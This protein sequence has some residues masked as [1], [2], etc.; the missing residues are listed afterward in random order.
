MATK[1]DVV[2]IGGGH[3]GLVTAFYLARA[4]RKPLVLER[5][6]AVGGAAITDE[7]HAGFKVPTLAHTLGP[8]R[9][10]VARDMALERHGLQVIRPEVRVFAPHPDGRALFLYDDAERSGK[11]IAAFSAKDATKYA[12][13]QG[14]LGRI[15][16][17][18][19]QVL[20]MPPPSLDHP[21]SGDLW[22]LL[23]IGRGLRGLGKKEMYHVLRW[24]PMAVADLVA[25]FFETEL[26]RAVIA[27]RGVFGASLGP[28]SAGTS[29]MLLMR[30]AGDGNPAGPTLFPKGGMGA[31]TQAMAAAATQA[32]AEIRTG[33]DVR[34]IQIKDGRAT[35][36][37]LASGETIEAGAVISN[38]DP[39]RT[40]LGLVDPVH[41]GPEFIVRARN[42]RCYGTVAKVN[43]ALSGLPEFTALKHPPAGAPNGSAALS[44]RIHIGPEIDYL[45]RAFDDS[46]YGDFSKNPYLDVTIP[47]TELRA[48][49][50][51][52]ECTFIGGL[53]QRLNANRPQAF[54]AEVTDVIE[55][56]PTVARGIFA[57][58]GYIQVAPGA[59]ACAGARDHHA[60]RAVGQQ[61]YLRLRSHF[62]SFRQRNHVEARPRSRAQVVSGPRVFQLHPGSHAARSAHLN[63]CGSGVTRGLE[64][65]E[66]P[67]GSLFGLIRM[68]DCR[69]NPSCALILLTRMCS[70]FYC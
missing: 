67:V 41:L 2:I 57:P 26:L 17:V 65:A 68:S 51:K 63:Q 5:R 14:T 66:L 30:A 23:K 48:V 9:A 18:M 37:V 45:E 25:E 11:S 34:Q 19:A 52:L 8:L 1:R 61:C 15:G 50:V 13:F 49:G 62:L 53:R 22:S 40:L 21:S 43:L 70:P 39:R 3:N 6:P 55:L 29:F 20:E 16:K 54:V 46:K 47:S 36:V 42:Y 4:G 60:V 32:G 28:W 69:V 10:D 64:D 24:G 27:A 44:G 33:A 31:V 12:E 38:A 56:A 35:G 58:T 59:V 7:L